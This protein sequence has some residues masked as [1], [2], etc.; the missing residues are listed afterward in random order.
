LYHWYI[1]TESG[2]GELQHGRQVWRRLAIDRLTHGH[3]NS[4]EHSQGENLAGKL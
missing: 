1:L 3:G 4:T 2:P